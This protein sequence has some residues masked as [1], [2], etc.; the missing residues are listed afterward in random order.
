VIVLPAVYWQTVK[1][2]LVTSWR[3]SQVHK[4][5]RTASRLYARSYSNFKG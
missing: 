3:T 1:L 2:V 4:S 5:W